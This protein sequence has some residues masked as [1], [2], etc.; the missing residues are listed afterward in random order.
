MREAMNGT[1]EEE[2]D[3]NSEFEGDVESQGGV[4]I[5]VKEY[6]DGLE[7]DARRHAALEKAGEVKTMFAVYRIAEGV[8]GTKNEL[9]YPV[10]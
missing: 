9:K 5:A 4:M 2:G 1:S 7:D 8:K 3:A 10:T 6:L